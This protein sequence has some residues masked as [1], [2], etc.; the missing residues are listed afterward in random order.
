MFERKSQKVTVP[1]IET[2]QI[3]VPTAAGLKDAIA[4]AAARAKTKL[5]E[6]AEH[7]RAV[8]TPKL[9]EARAALAPH[10]QDAKASFAPRAADARG[11]VE[12]D[13]LPKMVDA[14]DQFVDETLPKVVAALS[15]AF[16]SDS[17]VAHRASDAARVL[18]GDAVAQTK[19]QKKGGFLS[20]LLATLGILGTAGAAA[21]FFNK[22]SAE[23][24]DPW[25]RPLA[26]P[27]VGQ[28]SDVPRDDND[29]IPTGYDATGKDA[30]VTAAGGSA[31]VGTAADGSATGGSAAD[32]STA[33]SDTR[34][35]RSVAGHDA[36]QE[37]SV[38]GH[39]AGQE[40]SVAGI[41]HTG[42]GDSVIGHDGPGADEG[43]SV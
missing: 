21:W 5:G 17:E 19:Q 10:L 26:E 4:P 11:H 31:A 43:R 9:E 18:R 41:D 16:A 25:A 7:G 15:A 20:G 23:R 37:R 24:D 1:A 22:K 34:Q 14:K 12:S 40:R 33:G 42:S 28:V 30:S 39:D 29:H 3:T 2:R 36:G 13:Y 38:A 32:G 27:S 6:Q 8:A 35:E